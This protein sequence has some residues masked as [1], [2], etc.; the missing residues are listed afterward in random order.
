MPVIS[1]LLFLF[2]WLRLLRSWPEAITLICQH[3]VP[4]FFVGPDLVCIRHACASCQQQNLVRNVT[5]TDVSIA[6]TNSFT[7]CMTTQL[8]P[9]PLLMPS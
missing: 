9:S 3:S 6:N 5:V 1:P 4:F 7:G 2:H 8:S